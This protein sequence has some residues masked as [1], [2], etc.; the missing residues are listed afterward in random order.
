MMK[1]IST[2]LFHRIL[3]PEKGGAGPHPALLLLHGRG[4][5]EEDLLGLASA[6]DERLFI[7]SVRAPF[8]YEFGGYTWY[9]AGPAGSP[10]P[11]RF[12]TSCD[13][14]SQFADD[15]RAQYP[16]DHRK[17]FLLGFSMGCV[18]A[19]GL[20]LSRPGIVRGVSANSGY[21]PMETHL[22]LRWQEQSETRYFITH[23]TLD[24]VIPVEAARRTRA[25]FEKSNAPFL[26][27]EYAAGHQLTDSCVEDIAGW[28][29]GLL[30]AQ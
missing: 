9:D 23:G 12:R 10:E 25:L 7:I 24:P 17:F 28:L 21:V 15:I 13:G 5:D 18:M 2:S 1:T 8:P 27:R 16:I 20:A 30:D 11:Q 29:R 22:S 6:F 14:L 4:A 3:P 19:L 26:Y